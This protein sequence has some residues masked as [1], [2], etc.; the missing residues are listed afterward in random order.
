M[1]AAGAAWHS[2]GI[3]KRETRRCRRLWGADRAEIQLARVEDTLGVKAL[4]Q[5][6]QYLQPCA[7]LALH[8]R[9]QTH[10]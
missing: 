3:G 6:A 8:Q 9:C 2:L 1:V 7:M 10:A 5:T 4:F